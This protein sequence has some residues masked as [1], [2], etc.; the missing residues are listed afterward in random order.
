MF[1][2]YN[3][4]IITFIEFKLKFKFFSP[5]TSILY[6]RRHISVLADTLLLKF[7]VEKHEKKFKII[8]QYI[9]YKN[10]IT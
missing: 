3:I 7:Y 4:K 6:R 8:M 2:T 10:N 9:T 1:I 5:Y